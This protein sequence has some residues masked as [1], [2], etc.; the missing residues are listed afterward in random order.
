MNTEAAHGDPLTYKVIGSFFEV[1][2]ELGFGFLETVYQRAVAY[3]LA[4]QGLL[5][6]VGLLV[7]FGQKLTFERFLFTN[8]RKKGA[9][10]V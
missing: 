8:D 4:D 3:S 1:Y 2:R 7:N 9:F 5:I 10:R 6:E